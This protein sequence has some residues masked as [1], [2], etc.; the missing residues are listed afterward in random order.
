M[1]SYLVFCHKDGDDPQ[2]H[3]LV[4]REE[5]FARVPQCLKEI[6]LGEGRFEGSAILNGQ[7]ILGGD[8]GSVLSIEGG[9]VRFLHKKAN[10]IQNIV[11]LVF[12][13]EKIEGV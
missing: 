3:A 2:K 10:K 8:P 5:G 9:E 13:I 1:I 11:F 7:E 6:L 12:F 4:G